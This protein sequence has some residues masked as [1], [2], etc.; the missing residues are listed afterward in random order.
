[1]GTPQAAD[2]AVR[3]PRVKNY[4]LS[5]MRFLAMFSLLTCHMF[6]QAGHEI[7]ANLL[8]TAVQIFLLLSGYLYAHKSFDEPGSRVSFVLKNFVKILLD[9][10]LCVFLLIIPVYYFVAPENLTGSNIYKMLLTRSGWQ[11]VHHLWYVCHCLLCYMVT[12]ALYDLKKYFRTKNCMLIG[13]ILLIAAMEVLLK[14]Y[15]SYFMAYWL[16]CY[17]IGFFLPEIKDEKKLR[18]LWLISAVVGVALTVLTYWY[19]FYYYDS[20]GG[21]VSTAVYYLFVFLFE[22]GVVTF[23]LGVFLTLFILTRSVKW[24]D[25]TKKIFDTTDTL[26]YDVYLVHMIFVE[27]CLTI[28]GK[29]GNVW[30]E[31]VITIAEVFV[32]AWILHL[33]SG[34]LKPHVNKLTDKL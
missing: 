25:W 21:Q 6:Q 7:T 20:V 1:M 29:L 31:A 23:G 27:G 12:P 22:Y 5:L 24:P 26:S 28:I 9:Y 14:S 8:S 2:G 19:K 17:V 15:E 10:Y 13:V 11:G 3:A 4:S 33:I 16:S 18:L 30:L 34:W 32:T